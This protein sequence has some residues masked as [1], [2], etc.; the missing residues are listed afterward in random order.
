MPL[1]GNIKPQPKQM[2]MDENLTFPTLCLQ[3]GNFKPWTQ[4]NGYGWKPYITYFASTQGQ[5]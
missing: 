4:A 5:F 1:K 3:K 2:G